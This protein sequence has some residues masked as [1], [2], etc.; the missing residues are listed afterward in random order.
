MVKGMIISTPVSDV[1]QCFSV[2][3]PVRSSGGVFDFYAIA[4]PL[5]DPSEIPIHLTLSLKLN[6]FLGEYEL[7]KAIA[8]IPNGLACLN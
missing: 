4:M 5:Y 7:P 2:D 3:S 1:L 6:S 8:S